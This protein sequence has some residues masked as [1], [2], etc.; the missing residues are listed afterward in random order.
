[1]DILYEEKVKSSLLA[2]IDKLADAENAG[3]SGRAVVAEIRRQE[4]GF[5][6]PS[7]QTQRTQS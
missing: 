4:A 1:M 3:L 7:E 6:K 2:G 5:S